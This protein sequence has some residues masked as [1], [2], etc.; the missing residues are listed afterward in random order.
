[1]W[2]DEKD[3][4]PDWITF[5]AKLTTLG[6]IPIVESLSSNN[7]TKIRGI[8]YRYENKTSSQI[9][10]MICGPSCQSSYEY[11]G[12][13]QL[14]C[15]PLDT[16]KHLIEH[17]DK[18]HSWW[19]TNITPVTYEIAIWSSL[20][21]PWLDGVIKPIGYQTLTQIITRLSE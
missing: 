21:N 1:M 19:K 14:F 17:Y 20:S 16:S 4:N 5:H 9:L 13:G 8:S 10:S 3:K 11:G 6:F 18:S 15:Y 2:L 12:G 7:N